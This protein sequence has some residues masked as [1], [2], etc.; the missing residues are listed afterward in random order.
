M[1]PKKAEG[2]GGH[3]RSLQVGAPPWGLKQ[4]FQPERSEVLFS[5]PSRVSFH[6]SSYPNAPPSN[7]PS[8]TS[9]HR[10]VLDKADLGALG[11]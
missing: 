6:P 7:Q 2:G 10:G 8:A 1:T 4:H 9:T 3:H 5:P 11:L